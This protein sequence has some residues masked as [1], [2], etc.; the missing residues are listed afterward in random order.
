MAARRCKD[1]G[2][3]DGP[4]RR[5]VF[6]GGRVAQRA[7]CQPCE[8]A[9]RRQRSREKRAGAPR[10]RLGKGP[11]VAFG[12]LHF[13]WHH[14]PALEWA[15]E[16]LAATKP[17]AVVQLGDLYDLYSFSRHPRNPHVIMPAEE[18]E[19]GRESAVW[20][21][22]Q[23]HAAAPNARLYQLTG[24]HDERTFK[25]ALRQ[26]PELA[27]IVGAHQRDLMRFDGVT[28][29][30]DSAQELVLAGVVYM[31]GFRSKLGDHAAHNGRPTVCGHS[32][33]AGVSYAQTLGGFVWELNAGWLGDI[34]APCFRY[35]SQRVFHRTTLSIGIVDAYGPRVALWPGAK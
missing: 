34:T 29:V 12:D 18:I 6:P 23:A 33:R 15:L 26:S 7:I 3:T 24:N 19:R 14:V 13:P 1:C 31:H 16:V 25:Q 20:F 5:G 22:K 2:G 8:A 10:I 30:D 4:F 17:A 11:V 9:R 21:W 35:G 32:H 27:D 28:T